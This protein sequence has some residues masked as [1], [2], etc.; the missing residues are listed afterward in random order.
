MVI[1][2][3]RPVDAT[4]SCCFTSGREFVNVNGLCGGRKAKLAI[5]DDGLQ[6]DRSD[7]NKLSLSSSHLIC[8][9]SDRG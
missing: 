4:S 2:L 9:V 6:L 8:L 3:S 1:E 5:N 7:L